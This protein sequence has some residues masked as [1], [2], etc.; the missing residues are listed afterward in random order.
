MYTTTAI[1][2][3]RLTIVSILCLQAI[4]GAAS[5]AHAQQAPFA[6]RSGVVV[7]PEGNALYT[8]APDGSLASVDLQTG[9]ERW[10]SEERLRPLALVNGLLW[11]H[12][13]SENRS[14]LRV[15]GLEVRRAEQAGAAVPTPEDPLVAAPPRIKTILRAELPADV[16][17][18]FE[19][20]AGQ[21]FHLA[22]VQTAGEVYLRWDYQKLTKSRLV[23][24]VN[25]TTD[26]KQLQGVFQIAAEGTRAAP[27]EP[28][29]IPVAEENLLQATRM[30]WPKSLVTAVAREE[31]AP[32]IL[33]AG[34]NWVAVQRQSQGAHETALLR[35][36]RM[37][38]GTALPAIMIA[39]TPFT[40]R[41][42]S[43]DERHLLV[44]AVDGA[45]ENTWRILDAGTGAVVAEL[46][47]ERV[48]AWFFLHDDAVIFE[49]FVSN[50]D[51]SQRS[52]LLTSVDI[53]SGEQQWQYAYRDT[54]YRGPQTPSRSG[55]AA[56]AAAP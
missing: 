44:S 19:D 17:V 21:L 49:S 2:K 38:D 12:A 16:E 51:D 31:I 11:A 35:R 36:W 14:E 5:A 3:V 40:Y 30:N 52:L 7:D 26:A 32:P 15:V 41:Y 34:G 27:N 54:V 18:L 43:A 33:R 1:R 13:P 53:A 50:D 39:E 48:G 56:P 45:E 25:E 23:L 46:N 42:P 29:L 6:F 22:V 4:A 20:E 55:S 10:R 28:A 24:D 37:S 9:E 47:H 8:M